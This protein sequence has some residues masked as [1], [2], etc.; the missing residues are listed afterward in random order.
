MRSRL[1]WYEN[2]EGHLINL[3]QFYMIGD[4]LD[5]EDEAYCNIYAYA[6]D[7]RKVLLDRER[8]SNDTPARI[9]N[10]RCLL[11]GIPND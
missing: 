2:T 11:E 1:K 4:E 3:D 6:L 8:N 7:G 10:I 9:E 5:P